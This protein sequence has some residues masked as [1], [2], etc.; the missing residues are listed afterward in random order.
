MVRP[1]SATEFYWDGT[2]FAAL[3]CF[4]SETHSLPL[5]SRT[6]SSPKCFPFAKRVPCGALLELKLFMLSC[7]GQAKETECFGR[8]LHSL[9]DRSLETEC[10]GSRLHSLLDRS[11]EKI[12]LSVHILH[13]GKSQN[14]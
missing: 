10:F 4:Q 5:G 3:S 14:T 13:Q 12:A 9:L 7:V 2:F 1:A 11:L 6:T 8:R